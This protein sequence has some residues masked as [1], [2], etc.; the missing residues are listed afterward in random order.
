[1]STLVAVHK[2]RRIALACDTMN[3][4]GYT[5]CVHATGPPKVIT[6]GSLLIGCAGFTVYRNALDHYLASK[7]TPKLDNERMVFQFFVQFWRDLHSKY[8][9]VNDQS[10]S[11]A[12]SPFADL[13]AEFLVVNPDGIFRVKEILSVSRFEKFCAIGSGAPHA[14]G[15]LH[16]LYERDLT[17]REIAETAVQAALVFNAKSGGPVQV[18]DMA[19]RQAK[20]RKPRVRKL[21][22][23]SVKS[24]RAAK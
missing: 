16:I 11:E 5:R 13:D 10:D 3:S 18:V 15:A 8:H 22:S 2:N 14:E 20:A 19:E 17:A 6:S 1:M 7:R 24:R 12:D 9:F 4:V 21:K 23:A